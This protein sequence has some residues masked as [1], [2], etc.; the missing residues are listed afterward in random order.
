MTRRWPLALLALGFLVA[1]LLV[2]TSPWA[3][4]GSVAEGA[5]SPRDFTAP[6]DQRYVSELRSGAERERAAHAVAPA[7]RLDMALEATQR[8][9]AADVLANLSL[10]R[11]SPE[12]L[13]Q[14]R[15]WISGFAEFATLSAEAIDPLVDLK[16]T[17]GLK[18]DDWDR[19]LEEVP[20]VVGQVM[21]QY[22]R[23]EDLT[24]VRSEI[25]AVVDPR[26]DAGTARLVG[27]LA[28]AFV[29]PNRIPDEAAI[30]GRQQQARAD[31]EA[32][33]VQVQ[34]GSTIV[35][36]GDLVTPEIYEALSALGLL[37][38]NLDGQQLLSLALSLAALIAVLGAALHHLNAPL[39]D[40]PGAL[41]FI[42]LL[43][44]AFTATA[45]LV[46]GLHPLALYA[47]PAS[48]VAMT[49]AVVFS[50]GT[51]FISAMLLA[52][53]VGLIEGAGL[54]PALYVLL[55]GLAGAII[56]V[57]VARLKAFV[58]AGLILS[59]L[60]AALALSQV[61]A[62]TT[63]SRDLALAAGLGV[64]QALVATG[65]AALGI[66][67]VGT[68]FG[69]ATPFHLYELM[70][71]DHPLVRQLQ[72]QAPGT[73]QHSMV[74][75]NLVEG[76]ASAVGADAL[77]VRAGAYFHDVGKTVRPAFFVEN[78]LGGSS[79]HEGLAP[80]DS[81]R[82]ILDHVTDGL[83]LL[84]KHRLPDRLLDFVREH[85]G[86]N[87]VEYFYRRALEADPKAAA[88]EARF[89]YPGPR[90]RSRET[91]ILMLA[92]GAEAS[93]RAAEA[94]GTAAVDAVVAKVIQARQEAGELDDSGLSLGDLQRIR[95]AFVD[96]LRGMYHPRVRYPEGI[97]P[98]PETAATGA[99]NDR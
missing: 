29:V 34:A 3:Q 71:P 70:R 53:T 63:D 87:R 55:G 5:P 51:G 64:A 61:L 68:L 1:L 27:D 8:Q 40:R 96:T 48:A 97:Q 14:K 41:A 11:Q 78:Q 72:V 86:T 85:H 83:D 15:Q 21:R 99:G 38:R 69:V 44:L 94:G 65:L 95:T 31:A 2:L 59:V 56:M 50:L 39:F 98:L 30:A 16:A 88:D 32:V 18:P 81:A 17:G 10:L 42:V 93:V 80:A 23:S 52:A 57:R 25:G 91:A 9:R 58:W 77:L 82:I 36:K 33:S 89:R 12:T 74:L 24:A 19:L 66:L 60:N 20:R 22:I 6:R 79:A 45:R 28:A 37:P 43:D 76:A 90:P 7:Y 26:L 49:L 35:R 47:V 4:N 54:G 67:A 13:D 84:R 46:Q 92:D 75:A 62:G 73:Y